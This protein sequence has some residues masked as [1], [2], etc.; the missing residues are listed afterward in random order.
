MFLNFISKDQHDIVNA[1]FPEILK[2][3]YRP[4]LDLLFAL[5]PFLN[6]S[7]VSYK[8]CLLGRQGMIS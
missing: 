4:T 3:S 1:I 2:E 8:F 5:K 6:L 7:N